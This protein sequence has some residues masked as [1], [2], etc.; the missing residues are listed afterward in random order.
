MTYS[1][2]QVYWYW[3]EITGEFSHRIELP[4]KALAEN[5]DFQVTNIHLFHPLFPELALQADLLVL[6]MLYQPEL[7]R[8]IALRRERGLPTVFEIPDNFLEPGDWVAAD[9]PHRNPYVRQNLLHHA[10][11]CD[12]LQ[13]SSPELVRVFGTLNRQVEVFENQIEVPSP[14]PPEREPGFVFGWG[15][16]LGHRH[17]LAWAAPAIIGMCRRHPDAVFAYMG[18]D[19]PYEQFFSEI[20]PAQRLF[21][22]YGSIEEWFAFIRTLHVGLA[23]LEDTPFNRSRSDGKFLEYA[24]HGAAP[25]LSDL[26]VYRRHAEHACLFK[27]PDDLL[28]VLEQLYQQPPLVRDLAARAHAYVCRERTPRVHASARAAFYE[29]LLPAETGKTVF[30]ELP[31]CRRLIGLVREGMQHYW[32]KRYAEALAVLK[33]AVQSNPSYALADIWIMKILNQAGEQAQRQLLEIYT[34]LT[35]KSIYADLFYENLFL[36]AEVCDPDRAPQWLA[37]IED[38]VRRAHLLMPRGRKPADVY[39]ENLAHRP[40]DYLSLTRLRD[41]LAARRKSD[42]AEV[43]NLSARINFIEG[44]GTGDQGF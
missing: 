18:P 37:R 7:S 13:L 39:R 30:P 41:L 31:P 35:P 22:G 12:G 23:P 38:P 26:P 11:I 42:P 1:V 14:H 25:V 28:N 17:D 34:P 21:V 16:S 20:P 4:G 9:N 40:F 44:S 6:H 24:A 32:S 27:D 29:K 8:V 43:A 33:M 36:A 5:A 15:G 2:L 10:A 3:D 19:A